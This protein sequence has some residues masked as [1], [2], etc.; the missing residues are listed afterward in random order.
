MGDAEP[1]DA[2]RDRPLWRDRNFAIFL[3]VQTASVGGDAFS[4]VALPLLVLHATGSVAR[5]GLVTAL[6]GA[7]SIVAGIFAG[8]LADR[9][10]RRSLLIACDAARA[11]LYGLVV[12]FPH[13][14]V[15]YVVV[16]LGAALGMVFE[17]T[18]VTVV[19]ALV[20]EGQIMRANSR[21]Y[22]TYAVAS[23]VGPAVAGTLSAAF[24]PQTAIA[25]DAASFAVS[26][27]GLC[28]VR[29]RVRPGRLEAPAASPLRDVLAGARFLWRHPVL[30]TLTALL[31]FLTF[32]TYGLT[33]VLIYRLERDLGQ[34][35]GV[36]GYVLAAAACGSLGAA[37]LAGPLRGRFGFG[38]TWIGAYA[39]GGLAVAALGLVTSVP[40]VAVLAA[41][42]LFC[43][44]AAGISS[45]SLRQE[46]TPDHL[47]GRV[48]SAFWTV[49]SALG[50]VGAAALTWA[51]A[52]EGTAAVFAAA[53]TACLAAALGAVW[54]PLGR[55]RPSPEPT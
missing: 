30:R 27:A 54:T 8:V 6:A 53:G 46:I 47:L 44:G 39:L 48:T 34:P 18:Y 12:A 9:L 37:L 36:A 1:G 10:D 19:P 28:L 7:A 49:H 42:F 22:G 31:S 16:P 17:V 24:G 15:V 11:V 51:A 52:R 38:P 20:G 13:L 35:D 2:G 33:D 32:V 5:M 26:A 50:P 14:G 45:M 41:A 4:A 55:S 40:A 3:G 25:V 23:V 43:T 29:L 21:L